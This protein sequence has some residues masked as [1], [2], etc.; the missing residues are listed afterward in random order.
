[1]KNYN[2]I[3]EEKRQAKINYNM[4][5]NKKLRQDKVIKTFTCDMPYEKMEEI[6]T[7]LSKNGFTKKELVIAG[8]NALK[9][10]KD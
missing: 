6:N 9:G 10:K 8:Y 5:R 4:E 7:F 2:I 3:D 1:M